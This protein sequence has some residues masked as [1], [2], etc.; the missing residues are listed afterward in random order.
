[1]SESVHPKGI[2]AT[3]L[4]ASV[5]GP[6]ARDD[7]HGSRSINPM[8][9]YHNQVTRLQGGF[10]LRM[11]HRSFGLMLLQANIEAPCTLLDFPS[12]DRFVEEIRGNHY[13]V[14]GISSI[15]PNVGKVK[16]MCG[17][18][19]KHLPEATIVVGGHVA[20]KP[21]L[22]KLIDADHIVKGDGVRWFRKFL[23]QD[24][25]A[26]VRHPVVHSAFGT[27]VVG[28]GLPERP[29]STAAMLLPSVGCPMGCNF[30]STS[31]MFGGKG[32]FINFYETGDDLFS[33]MCQIEARLGTRSFFVMDEN[34]L[35]HRKRALRLLDLMR[36]GGKSW[37][38]YVFSSAGILESYS[39]EQLVGLGISWVWLGLEGEASAYRKLRGVET[40]Q[41]VP[42]L[43]SHGIRVLGSTIIG[44]E[45]HSPSTID[46]VIDY[47]VGHR[48][49]FHQFML[50]TPIPGTAL[51]A[52][53]EQEGSLLSEE[54]VPPADAHGQ[55]R[56]NF[57]HRHIRDGEET[58]F[59]LRAFRRDFEVNGPSIVRI[60]RTTLEGWRRYRSHPDRR[61]RDRFEREARDLATAHAGIVWA[62]RRRFR[63]DASA[64][65]MMTSH[66]RELKEAFGWK[67]RVAAAVLGRIIHASLGLEERRL[68]RGWTREPDTWYEKNAQAL[69]CEKR[70]GVRPRSGAR[71]IQ[72]VSGMPFPEPDISGKNGRGTG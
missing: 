16:V 56:F 48:T 55:F 60:S 61:I 47:A 15:L 20:N 49:D 29:G 24:V 26:P 13:D 67:A 35:L 23:R 7:E 66:L 12:L 65:A 53:H 69:A 8:E 37:S 9:L 5:F 45:D 36:E 11:F 3:V 43:Q 39:I 70:G 44:L 59:L 6:Y 25:D 32:R 62:A 10:S 14:V 57:R 21:G 31:A 34:F 38:L 58:G 51:Y 63:K 52:R 1:M 50:Y 46:A 41:L 71:G 64:V 19:R 68:A 22:E 42:M 4:L 28:L 40:R 18:V 72:W 54:T 2:R 17:L 33:V 27:R 30:C